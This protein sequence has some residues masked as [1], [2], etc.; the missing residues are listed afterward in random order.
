MYLLAKNRGIVSKL[1]YLNKRHK[2]TNKHSDDLLPLFSDPAVMRSPPPGTKNPT[3]RQI[4]RAIKLRQRTLD[5]KSHRF[6]RKSWGIGVPP[7]KDLQWVQNHIGG[8]I[9]ARS[10]TPTVLSRS[11]NNSD[12]PTPHPYQPYCASAAPT[13]LAPDIAEGYKGR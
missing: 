12:P 5:M 6:F 11:V 3:G 13:C 1:L 9:S 10:V 8:R 7:P 4:I 2:S